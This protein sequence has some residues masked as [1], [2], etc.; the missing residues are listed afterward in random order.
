MKSLKPLLVRGPLLVFML[1]GL[2]AAAYVPEPDGAGV[3]PGV[4]PD[5]WITG[6]PKCMESPEFQVHEYNPDFYI[7]RQS[8]C[9]HYEKPFLYLLFG[10]ERALLIDTGAGKTQVGRVVMEVVQKW[11][12]RNGRASIPL[13]VAHSHNHC[14]HVAGDN[15]SKAST[16]STYV[17]ADVDTVVE[18]WGF[19][20]WP[21]RRHRIRPGRIAF[22]RCSAFPG[23]TRLP[24]L[25]TTTRPACCS[26]ATPFIQGGCTSTIRRPSSPASIGWSSSR[27]TKSW[28]TSSAATS[29]NRRHAVSRVPDR[30]DLPAG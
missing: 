29:S 6:G 16:T 25:S 22:S 26:A 15:S 24:S 19:K 10:K 20:N 3:R 11:C 8:G 2:F 27:W 28:R 18:Y 21:E 23:T 14:D 30:V 12:D 9:S 17:G 7:L 1:A 13:I 5:S 4:L